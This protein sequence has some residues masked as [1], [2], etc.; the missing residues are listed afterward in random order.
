[1]PNFPV[2]LRVALGLHHCTTLAT[3][4]GTHNHIK[5][6]VSIINPLILS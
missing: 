6:M 2:R 1:M 5:N 4:L 3:F